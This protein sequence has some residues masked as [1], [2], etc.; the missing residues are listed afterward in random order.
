MDMQ[1]ERRK[2][3]LR[4]DTKDHR[5]AAWSVCQMAVRLDHSTADELERWRVAC[6][7]DC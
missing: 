1:T 4:V 7:E 3:R 2:G 5:W 6:W